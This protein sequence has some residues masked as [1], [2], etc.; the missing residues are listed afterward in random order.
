MFDSGHSIIE[1]S[2]AVV[3]SDAAVDYLARLRFLFELGFLENAKFGGCYR[4]GYL[5]GESTQTAGRAVGPLLLSLANVNA[6]LLL[7]G[8]A[9]LTL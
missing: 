6:D 3:V 4:H 7:E 8:R 9:G 1:T 2:D 5:R